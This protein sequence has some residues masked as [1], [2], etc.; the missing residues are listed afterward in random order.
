MDEIKEAQEKL[1]A[2]VPTPT[3]HEAPVPKSYPAPYLPKTKIA[4]T[5][6]VV[7]KRSQAA[8]LFELGNKAALHLNSVTLGER[9]SVLIVDD[10]YELR[11]IDQNTKQVVHTFPITSTQIKCTLVAGSKLFI[12]LTSGAVWMYD[13]FPPYD[14]IG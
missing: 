3:F 14:R 6:D 4:K 8:T 1:A 11:V 13:A 10:T 2:L 9:E 12:G 7:C 5:L